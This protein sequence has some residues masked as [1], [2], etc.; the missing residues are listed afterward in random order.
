FENPG[1]ETM[2]KED[3]DDLRGVYHQ[4]IAGQY[5]REKRQIAHILRKHGIQSI[6]T[7]PENL[8][9]SVINKYLELKSRHI[10]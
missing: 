3:P 2:A 1:I 4:V 9:V 7:K 10:M 6:L 5:L 8:N